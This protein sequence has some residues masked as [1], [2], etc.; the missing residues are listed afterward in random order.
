VA[1]GEIAVVDVNVG[2]M[3]LVD[4]GGEPGY[5]KNDAA[6][7]LAAFNEYVATVQANHELS[8]PRDAEYTW[9]PLQTIEGESQTVTV[10]PTL[11]WQRD[12]YAPAS[13]LTAEEPQPGWNFGY[14]F[15]PQTKGTYF[16]IIRKPVFQTLRVEVAAEDPPPPPDPGEA[17][18]AVL[19]GD[20]TSRSLEL[21]MVLN[22]AR[23]AAHLE[24]FSALDHE[25]ENESGGTPAGLSAVLSQGGDG[26]Q[27][28]VGLDEDSQIVWSKPCPES[29]DELLALLPPPSAP[30]VSILQTPAG[31]LPD[32]DQL[33]PPPDLDSPFGL[34][35]PTA[36]QKRV[37]AANALPMPF[38]ALPLASWKSVDRRWSSPRRPWQQVG[39]TCT[40]NAYI[41][42]LEKLRRAMG[43]PPLQ[44]S[45]RYIYAYCN[46]NISTGSSIWCIESNGADIGVASYEF[47]MDGGEV[48]PSSRWPAGHKANA[49]RHRGVK[50]VYLDDNGA[51]L[52][53]QVGTLLQHGYDVHV[54]ITWPAGG[55]HS[56]LAVGLYDGNGDGDL[57]DDADG[58][59]VRNSWGDDW[60]N[61]GYGKISR[62]T[63]VRSAGRYG[64]ACVLSTTLP[65]DE[66]SYVLTP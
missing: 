39:G 28:L 11:V 13:Q 57:E 17:V 64:A 8:A 6:G 38:A 47:L 27:Q 35:E 43:L 12:K 1:I 33:P 63:Y 26:K 20:A 3:L 54:G 7:S 19:V 22:D 58:L 61:G 42:Q 36:E 15:T 2:E 16:V 62:A 53:S 24:D 37:L 41:A 52:Y 66:A 65:D 5:D 51:N 9:R 59:I 10:V 40:A 25:T 21:G 29:I 46:S 34:T 60:G 30:R 49:A 50:W 4:V 32:A 56:I 14:E 45:Y 31:Q 44:L 23:L 48:W 18:C 55:G